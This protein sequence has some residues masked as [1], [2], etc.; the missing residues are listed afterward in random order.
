MIFYYTNFI[1]NQYYQALTML[2]LL[3]W[4]GRSKGLNHKDDSRKDS[5]FFDEYLHDCISN[6]IDCCFNKDKLFALI[7]ASLKFKLSRFHWVCAVESRRHDFV[8]WP[9]E[10]R[11]WNQ[12]AIDLQFSHSVV[13]RR[14]QVLCLL[15]WRR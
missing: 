11:D 12:F 9:W 14:R 6:V 15:W 8:G 13:T 10:R 7:L 2:N 1:S 5:L 3:G 4:G